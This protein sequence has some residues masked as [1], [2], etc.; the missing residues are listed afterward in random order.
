MNEP[1][2]TVTGNVGAIPRHR[3][4]QGVPVTDFRIGSTPRRMDRATGEWSD[5]ETLWFSVSC[6]R[7][8]AQNVAESL[9][10]GDPVVVTGRLLTRS[11]TTESGETRSGLE[12]DATS[13]GLDLS[14][15]TAMLRRTER[16]TPAPGAGTD[17]PAAV[18]DDAG[19]EAVWE[20]TGEV[21][22][23]TGEVLM[24]QVPGERA[25]AAA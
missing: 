2:I 14:R 25:E 19:S 6:W 23:Q 12:I 7:A 17:A 10:K 9:R 4:V 1:Y 20:S 21:D 11:W 3:N 5:G 16:T 22:P 8:L 15:G 18:N 24:T 13:I